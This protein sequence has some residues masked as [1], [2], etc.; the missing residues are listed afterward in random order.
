MAESG[1][2][3]GGAALGWEQLS[4]APCVGSDTLESIF[5][6]ISE[7]VSHSADKGVTSLLKCISQLV[8]THRFKLKKKDRKRRQ[9]AKEAK[10]FK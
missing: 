5:D 4:L 2:P 8:V 10:K 9:A 1:F 7:L 3:S 6:I